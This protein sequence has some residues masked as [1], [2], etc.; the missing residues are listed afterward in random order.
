MGKRGRKQDCTTEE[1]RRLKRI[2]YEEYDRLLRV[3]RE[4]NRTRARYLQRA[5][6]AEIIFEMRIVPWTQEY[7]ERLLTD[8]GRYDSKR[9]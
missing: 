1:S 3:E 2:L 5:Y 4:E 8:R 9:G 6:Y 7:I